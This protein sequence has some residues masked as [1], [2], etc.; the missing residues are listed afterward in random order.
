M[1]FRD[2]FPDL[3]EQLQLYLKK[4]DGEMNVAEQDKN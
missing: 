2:H 3:T 4:T 1:R